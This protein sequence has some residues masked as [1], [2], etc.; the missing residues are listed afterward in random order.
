[1]E[2]IEFNISFC[3][4]RL[5]SIN[6]LLKIFMG[7]KK[8]AV[9]DLKNIYEKYFVEKS[10]PENEQ[11]WQ[12][13]QDWKKE[14]VDKIKQFEDFTNNSDLDDIF[15]KY[16]NLSFSV[17]TGDRTLS[18]SGSNWL[19][20]LSKLKISVNAIRIKFECASLRRKILFVIREHSGIVN[21]YDNRYEIR[22][23]N[24][25]WVSEVASLFD[26]TINYC[27]NKRKNWYEMS[28]FLELIFSVVLAGSIFSLLKV[29]MIFFDQ[30]LFDSIDNYIIIFLVNSLI[31]IFIWLL[32]AITLTTKLFEYMIDLYPSVEIML[33]E[34]RV[35][36]RKKLYYS[37]IVIFIP[38]VLIFFISFYGR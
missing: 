28:F 27:Y 16:V 35:K 37:F 26:S 21:T 19:E 33:D 23:I 10:Q 8:R 7:E 9:E 20:L 14:I 4:F 13:G 38:Y 22:G 15:A 6:A 2:K 3:T 29:C 34:K 24:S 31:Y 5:E 1:M 18:T 12:D 11:D 17:T 36:K 32:L 30:N 25:E